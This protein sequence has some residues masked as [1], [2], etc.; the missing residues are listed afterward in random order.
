MISIAATFETTPKAVAGSTSAAENDRQIAAAGW[1]LQL[2]ILRILPR[3][4]LFLSYSIRC[5]S[6]TDKGRV[7]LPL[8]TEVV[9]LFATR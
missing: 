8:S 4:K 2:A 5:F 7:E 9:M 6:S 3:Q 1:F